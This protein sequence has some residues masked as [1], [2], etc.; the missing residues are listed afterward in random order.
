LCRD[1]DSKDESK[2]VER[3]GNSNVEAESRL[4]RRKYGKQDI[5]M[6]ALSLIKELEKS[7]ARLCAE[8]QVLRNRVEAFEELAQLG[9]ERNYLSSS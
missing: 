7:S 8:K 5:I 9:V 2:P 1:L 3:V 6:H 4:V